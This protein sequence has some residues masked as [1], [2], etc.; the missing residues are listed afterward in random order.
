MYQ[1]LP[2]SKKSVVFETFDSKAFE[3]WSVCLKILV[4]QGMHRKM[5]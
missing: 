5:S 1:N 3:G 4:A 2:A